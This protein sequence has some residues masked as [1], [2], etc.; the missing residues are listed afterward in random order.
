MGLR[1]TQLLVGAQA[2][3]LVGGGG[4]RDGAVLEPRGLE[5]PVVVARMLI[6]LTGSRSRHN[7]VQSTMLTSIAVCM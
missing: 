2:L 4:D 7:G 3:P 5:Q 1:W 6:R